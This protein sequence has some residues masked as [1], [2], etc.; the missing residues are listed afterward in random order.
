MSSIGEL[1]RF[2]K[3]EPWQNRIAYTFM[4]LL[5]VLYLLGQIA[6]AI[7]WLAGEAQLDN[8]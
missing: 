1:K 6:M 4:L 5:A 3:D 8:V 7:V 2:I